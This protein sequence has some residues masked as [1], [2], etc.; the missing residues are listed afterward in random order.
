MTF[1]FLLLDITIILFSL[2][3]IDPYRF[4]YKASKIGIAGA[5][6]LRGKATEGDLLPNAA[7]FFLMALSLQLISLKDIARFPH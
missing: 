3:L 7:I 6:Y 4:T 1:H 5:Q 2:L